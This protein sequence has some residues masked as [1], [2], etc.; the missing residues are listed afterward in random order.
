TCGRL[1]ESLVSA[2]ENRHDELVDE[3]E[4]DYE[5]PEIVRLE[6][7]PRLRRL[8]LPDEEQVDERDGRDHGEN[9]ENRFR[10][11]EAELKA[12]LN[13]VLVA[14]HSIQPSAMNQFT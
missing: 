5:P 6:L 3:D 9:H 14:Y 10:K 11:R 1:E 4:S 7:P 12:E 8:Q 13:A 2:D